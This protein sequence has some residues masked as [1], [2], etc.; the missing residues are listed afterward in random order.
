M[1][2]RYD[3]KLIAKNQIADGTTE[4][5][6][7]KPAGF[8]YRAGQFGDLVLTADDGGEELKHGFS[9]VSAP[10][11]E[12]LAMATRMRGSTFKNAAAK[13]PVGSM[14]QML[15]LWG[16]F[17]LHNNT[18]VPAVFVIGGI[19]ITP[20]RSMIVQALH[21]KTEHDI[22]LIYANQ[23]VAQAAY[24]EE[25]TKLAA[26]HDNFHFVPVYTQEK[27]AGAE[28]GRVNAD[29]IRRHVSNIGGS[30]CYL[31][32]PEGMVKAM[33]GLLIDSGADE[34]NIRT[35]EFSGY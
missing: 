22:T 17:L 26:T 24:V 6:L 7:E 29:I 8:E 5:V 34:D 1:V 30:K 18:A 27:L 16:D 32:G 10:F 2:T 12:H 9:Y 33:R 3:V 25:L 28:S 14:V 13:V 19:G 20:V 11:E 31:S 23:T 35:E 15:A 4:F 21:D